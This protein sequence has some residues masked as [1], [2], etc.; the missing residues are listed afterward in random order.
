[1]VLFSGGRE[2]FLLKLT[3][4]TQRFTLPFPN[5][6]ESTTESFRNRNTQVGVAVRRVSTEGLQQMKR[7]RQFSRIFGDSTY[8]IGLY[9]SKVLKGQY[10]D[11]CIFRY[12]YPFLLIMSR[13]LR[14]CLTITRLIK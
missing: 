5:A 13:V 10:Y 8:A 6:T 11:R 1:M 14:K 3:H 12:I 4:N 7:V 2:L 9:Y